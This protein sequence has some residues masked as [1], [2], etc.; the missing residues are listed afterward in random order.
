MLKNTIDRAYGTTFHAV[1]RLAPCDPRDTLVIAGAPRSGTTWL[2]EVLQA[3]PGY[4]ALNEPL[5]TQATRGR[6]GFRA[7]SYIADGQGD[8]AERVAFLSAALEGRVGPE[9]RW[10]FRKEARPSALASH[11]WRRKMLV[12]FCRI[13]RMLPWF[14]TRF[15][16]RGLMFV[17]RHPCAVVNSMLRFGWTRVL[18][19][20]DEPWSPLQT[21]DLPDDVQR[22]FAP[23]VERV[24]DRVEALAV[25]WCMDHYLPLLHSDRHPWLIVPYERMALD[26]H[27]EIQ[28]LAGAFGFDVNPRILEKIGEP[29]SSVRGDVADDPHRQIAKWKTQMDAKDIDRVMSIVNACGL[30]SLYGTDAEPDYARLNELQA[31]RYRW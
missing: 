17:V 15:D 19:L 10:S 6:H 23:L 11:L 3:L 22:V 8:G 1:G 21:N 2:L 13:N 31:P 26:G 30:S 18:T 14:G 12:K 29:S 5:L 7:R 4:K 16:V 20:R 27:G 24:Q 28:R 9:L 25:I